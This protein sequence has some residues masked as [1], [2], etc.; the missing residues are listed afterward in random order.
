MTVLD[1][2]IIAV[3]VFFVAWGTWVGLIRQLSL[4]VA[5]LAGFAV[6]GRYA[7][8][9]QEVV[10][11]VIASPRLAFLLTYLVLLLLAYVLIRLLALV[12]RKLVNVSLTPWFD[13]VTGGA[14]GLAKGYLLLVIFYLAFSGLSTA[15]NPLLHNSW[16]S[17]YLE[18]GSRCLQSLVRDEALREVFVPRLPAISDTEPIPGQP[19]P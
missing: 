2:G 11:P 15:L 13:K 7:G 16:S 5:L 12:L 9:V 18:A 10:A 19:P 8:E 14:F 17:P 4:V 6:A 3:L 1:A